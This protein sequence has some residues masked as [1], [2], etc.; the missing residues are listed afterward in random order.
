MRQSLALPTEPSGGCY[1]PSFPGDGGRCYSVCFVF[2]LAVFSGGW[3]FWCRCAC[4]VAV[5]AGCG[6]DGVLPSRPSFVVPLPAAYASAPGPS[7]STITPPPRR[8]SLH[9]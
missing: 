8:R 1:R 3:G 7:L 4:R 2:L 6:V 9:C 5:V